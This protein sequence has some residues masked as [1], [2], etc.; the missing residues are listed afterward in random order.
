MHLMRRLL[1][2][3]FGAAVSTISLLGEAH[4]A[5]KQTCLEAHTEAQRARRQ[6]HLLA[7]KAQLLLCSQDRCPRPVAEDCTRWLSEVESEQPTVV[8]AAR[9]ES[10]R[11]VAEVLVF[12]DGAILLER[13]DGHPVEI[14]PGEHLVRYHWPNGQSAQDRVVVRE[15]EKDRLIEVARPAVAEKIAA[16]LAVEAPIVEPPSHPIPTIAWVLW[17]GAVAAGGSFAYF[18]VSGRVQESDLARTCKG[19]CAADDVAT[20]RR[21]YLIADVSWVTALVLGATATVIALW[22]AISPSASEP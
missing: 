19:L 2:L 10:G 7:A 21:K 16:P 8:F 15:G 11:D 4:A 6:A 3:L 12:V 20:V 5:D 14:D 18:G 13:L 22:P 17:G 9:D 1:I